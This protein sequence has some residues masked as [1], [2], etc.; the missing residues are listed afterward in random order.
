[1][2]SLPTHRDCKDETCPRDPHIWQNGKM[3]FLCWG[4]RN[5]RLRALID[6]RNLTTTSES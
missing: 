2:M 6:P 5:E 3:Q 1:M 4:F